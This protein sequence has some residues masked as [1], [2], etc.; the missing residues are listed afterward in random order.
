MLPLFLLRLSVGMLLALVPLSP[1]QINPRFYRTH[2]LVVLGLGSLALVLVLTGGATFPAAL[3][4]ALGL[5]FL[6]SAAWSIE[7]TPGGRVLIVLTLLALAAAL[8]PEWSAWRSFEPKQEGL[9]WAADD[10]TTSALLGVAISAMLLGHMYL[11]APSMSLAPLKRLLIA[12]FVALV[13][14]AVVAGLS[15]WLWSASASRPSGATEAILW[16]PLR[17]GLGLILPAVLGVLAW[18]TT[19]LRNTQSTTGILY[20][21]VVFVFLGELTALLLVNVTGY[22]L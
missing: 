18:R 20:V 21:V 19:L 5:A 1:A 17:W 13:A 11:I 3:G 4:V 16:L 2:F 15:L 8:Y 9:W 7:G 12:L 10:M 14:R 22:F 6:G